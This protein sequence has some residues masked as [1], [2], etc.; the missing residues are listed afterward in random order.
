MAKHDPNDLPPPYYSL[1]LHTQPPLKPYEEVVYGVGP[2]LTPP[3]HPRYIPQYPPPVVV[4]P[5]TQSSIP[6]SSK[7]RRCCHS[8]AQCCGGSGGT[9]LLLGLLALAIW[10]GVRYGT[11][12]A[13]TAILHDD[14]NDHDD[15]DDY[16]DT[17]PQRYDTCSNSTVKCDGII[18]CKLGS[19]ET[20]C[21]RF[22]KSNGL[23]VKTS[24]DGRFLP[25]CHKDWNNNY[26]DE[27]CAQLG[28][29]KSYVTGKIKSQ[30]ANVLSLTSRKSPLL[31][32]RVKVSSLCPNQ[33]AV[34]LQCVDCGRQKTTSRIIGGSAA[35]EGQW[36]W[37]VSLHFRGSH[38][39]GA[40]LI[41]RDFVLTAAHCFP[42]SNSLS[43]QNW[44]VYVGLMSLTRP[45]QPYMVK[46]IILNKNYNSN[47]N[48]QDVALLKLETQVTFNDNIH[49][50]CL[51]AFDQEFKPG[52]T[53]W[54]SGFGTTESGSGVVSKE[55]ME[56]TVDL[57]DTGVCNG[58]V[59]YQGAVTKHML[60]AGDLD[61][62]KDSCQGDSGGPLVCKGDS[63]WYLAGITSWG[64]GCGE[65]NRP[66]VYTKV[67]SVLPWIYSKM[68]QEKP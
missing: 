14:Y 38:V 8:N 4:S 3:S 48:D 44:K 18:D 54:T 30:G 15:H 67:K 47:T 6:P 31:Q 41:S 19:D 40:V 28:L 45:T 5:V 17:I 51:P 11:R 32:S 33:E 20:N 53:C 36:P 52:T 22:D 59:V 68:Q 26:A 46:R 21:V 9:L 35:K 27:T 7:R 50:A 13:T 57:I 55:L 2:G 61:G 23:Q 10:L 37:Q 60:C 42:S 66:G 1:D 49:P 62:G 12:L 39:C 34:S 56:V 24:Q 64:V 58:P 29:R 65:K 63:R 16:D 43:L 25:V